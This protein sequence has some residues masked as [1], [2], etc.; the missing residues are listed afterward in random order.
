MRTPWMVSSSKQMRSLGGPARGLLN[1]VAVLYGH[2]DLVPKSQQ[3]AQFR[4]GEAAAV[5]GAKQQQTKG[6]FLGLEADDHHAAQ[7]V[8][9]RQFAKAPYGFVALERGEIVVA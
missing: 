9:C 3:Q 1:Q 5:R 2:A 7:A 4:G 6:L 8:L